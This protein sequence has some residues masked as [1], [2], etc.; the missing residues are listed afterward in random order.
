MPSPVITVTG[1]LADDPELRYTPGGNPV[2]NFRVG[3]TERYRDNTSGEWKE[4]GTSWFSVQCWNDLAEH[5]A[6]SLTRGARVTVS[7]IMRQRSYETR[8]GEKRYIWEIHADE[9][10]ASLRYATVNIHKVT[11]DR[12]PAPEDPWHSEESDTATNG[13]ES[14]AAE[15][16]PAS[17][18]PAKRSKRKRGEPRPGTVS[19]A[20][21]LPPDITELPEI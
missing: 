19:P 7:G 9:V 1:N 14:N 13:S 11:R 10:S 5:V 8:D 2:S 17:A 21:A 18:T 4:R 20:G 6:E 3:V 12:G 15:S 16:E